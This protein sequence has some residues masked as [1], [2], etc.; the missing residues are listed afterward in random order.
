MELPVLP[1]KTWVYDSNDMK[2]MPGQPANAKSSHNNSHHFDKLFLIF[3]NTFISSIISVSW[4]LISPK[5][6]GTRGSPVNTLGS[7]QGI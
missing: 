6:I 2:E 1:H 7:H 3:H 5:F 4:S